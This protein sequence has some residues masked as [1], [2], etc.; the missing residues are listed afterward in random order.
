MNFVRL[1]KWLPKSLAVVVV[2]RIF[3]VVVVVVVVAAENKYF[4]SD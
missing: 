4:Q 3:K 2:V 1:R